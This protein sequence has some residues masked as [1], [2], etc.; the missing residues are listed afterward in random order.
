MVLVIGIIVFALS[1]S[2]LGADALQSVLNSLSPHRTR[3][4]V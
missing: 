4:V 2:E 1:Q 3:E